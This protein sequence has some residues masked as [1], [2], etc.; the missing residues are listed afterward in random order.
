M[1]KEELIE[2][3][4]STNVAVAADKGADYD[5]ESIENDRE[6]LSELDEEALNQE[7]ENAKLGTQFD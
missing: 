1:G 5:D 7:L 2:A 4:I 3:I 6:Y